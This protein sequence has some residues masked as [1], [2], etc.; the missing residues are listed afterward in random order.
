MECLVDLIPQADHQ[1]VLD[2]PVVALTARWNISTTNAQLSN[3]RKDLD[4]MMGL[5]QRLLKNPLKQH[6]GAGSISP[7]HQESREQPPSHQYLLQMPYSTPLM[8]PQYLL[9]STQAQ[10]PSGLLYPSVLRGYT[11]DMD[12]TAN[13]GRGQSMDKGQKNKQGEFS[14]YESDGNSAASEVLPMQSYRKEFS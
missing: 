1:V 13:F 11:S 12:H 7:Y 6:L 10:H 2:N 3:I 4:E 8:E 14:G 5:I 9:Q